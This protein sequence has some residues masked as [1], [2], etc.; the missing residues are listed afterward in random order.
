MTLYEKIKDKN[1]FFLM[2]GPCVIED[3]D[4]MVRIAEFLKKETQKRNIPFIFKASF[5][6]ANRTSID[7][8]SG[9][10]IDKGLKI[11]QK[12]KNALDVK[13]VT[14]IH[15]SSQAEKITEVA[16]IIQI[17][18]FLSRQTKLILSAAKTGKI[19]NVKKAQ[20]MAPEDTKN[21]VE[22]ILSGNNEKI[23]LTERGVSFGYHNLVVDFRS[24]PIMSQLGY[25]VVYD[26]THSLQMPSL[27]KNSGGTPQ[28]APMMANAAIATGKVDGLFIE[29]H[30]NPLVAK[31]DAKSMI[32]LD[33]IPNLLDK[34][35][36]I[37]DIVREK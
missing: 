32:Q 27:G 35:K 3:Y 1:S 10:G 6:K 18:A 8:Y 14:D 37:Y 9:P 26:V 21:I 30:P 34:C 16:D 12:I 4:I 11:L 17:P 15:L 22:K 29:T 20:F 25:P 19:V 23:M 28:Y 33:Q 2:A 31:S 36:K 7:S 13:I 24:F 5:E